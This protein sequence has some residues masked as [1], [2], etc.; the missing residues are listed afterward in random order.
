MTNIA[1]GAVTFEAGGRTY[2]LSY[3]V[4]A[5]CELEIALGE[6]IGQLAARLADPDNLKVNVLRTFV[7]GGLRDHHAELTEEDAGRLMTEIG[8]S[9]AISIVL[10]AF[11]AAFPEADQ[12][13]PLGK[14]AGAR[15]G[16]G[17]K[18]SRS[19]ASPAAIPSSSGA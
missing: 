12:G 5:L 2:T 6:G 3:S 14:A 8:L 16:A 9:R 10:Q 18:S 1:R 11:L 13:R 19:G 4:N 7:W 15:S 17:K